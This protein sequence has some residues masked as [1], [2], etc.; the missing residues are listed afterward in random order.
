MP[1]WI[2]VTTHF[3]C[4]FSVSLFF[5]ASLSSLSHPN[6]QPPCSPGKVS[7]APQRKSPTSMISR[8]YHKTLD[9]CQRG[10]RG[11]DQEDNWRRGGPPLTHMRNYSYT[12]TRTHTHTQHHV[13]NKKK[14][15]LK[16]PHRA[17]ES[18]EHHTQTFSNCWFDALHI[19]SILPC[20]TRR[21]CPV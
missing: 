11:G 7:F 19:Y 4:S 10:L 9:K 8:A 17:G 2:N 14:K 12:H 18:T 15:S 16:D 21:S 5:S 3:S 20:H 6:R 1:V 13:R